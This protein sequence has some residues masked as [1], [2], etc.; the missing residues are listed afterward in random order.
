M[1][2]LRIVFTGSPGAGKSTAIAAL[3]EARPVI[4]PVAGKAWPAGMDLGQILLDD[5]RQ[6][7]LL[8]SPGQRGFDF[9]WCAV[10]RG[11]LG[12]V[13]LVD[14]TRPD[15]LAD[16]GLHLDGFSEELTDLPCVIGVGRTDECSAP[17]LDEY[18][19]FLAQQGL[20]LPVL[21]VDVRQREDVLQLMDLLLL[22]LETMAGR[23]GEAHA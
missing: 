18:S 15:P 22:Q 19:D 7:R 6:V 13:I 11:A 12:L 1:S 8:G 5:G 21:K 9:A 23:E 17:S 20:V 16:L 2:D 4:T 14:N 10:A 3:S